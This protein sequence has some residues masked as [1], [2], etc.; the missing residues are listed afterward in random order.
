MFTEVIRL[1][2]QMSGQ[3]YLPDVSKAAPKDKKQD[4]NIMRPIPQELV[5]RVLIHTCGV[6]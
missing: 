4:T 3:I 6:L 2:L 1:A 5:E